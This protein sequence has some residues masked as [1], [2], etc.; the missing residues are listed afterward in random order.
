MASPAPATPSEQLAVIR[1]C[2]ERLAKAAAVDPA[3]LGSVHEDIREAYLLL[4]GAAE[5]VDDQTDQAVALAS[6][7]AVA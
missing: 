7:G 6:A 2:T 4:L 3:V 5:Y 1:Y